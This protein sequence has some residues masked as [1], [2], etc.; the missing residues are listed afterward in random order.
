MID[1]NIESK[2]LEYASYYPV[3]TVTG[4][5][6][7]G[8]TTLCKKVFPDK[9]YISLETIAT[10]DY[11]RE[12][13]HGFLEEYRQG[14]I[15]DE[16]Q[17][18][19]QL[20]SYLQT[21]VDENPV[22]GR[23]ILTGSQHF[24][25]SAS[26]AQSMAGRTGILHLLPLSFDEI[27]RF[28]SAPDA[29]LEAMWTGGYPRILDQQIPPQIWLE[30]YLTTYVQ[31]DV[32]QLLNVGDLSAFVSFVR[33]CAGRTGQI[34]NLSTLGADCGISHNTARAWLSV[35]ETSFLIWRLPA[36][37]T[38]IRKQIV[39]SPKIHFLDS[40]L[41]CCLLGIQTP[42][43]LRHHPLRG[44]IFESWAVSEVVK[45][46]MQAGMQPRL[47][48][49]RDSRGLEVD[50]VEEDG[51][52]LILTELK[53]GQ[54]ITGQFFAPLEKV[55]SLILPDPRFSRVQ[56]RVIYG[57]EEARASASMAVVPWRDIKYRKE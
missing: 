3:V 48:H 26:I 46:R 56:T 51:D 41:V 36:W 52:Q 32:R 21:D 5:R 14:A 35:L 31:R 15:L 12:D 7:S 53:S 24:A 11:A 33:L 42:E 45:Q 16:I 39:K 43:Q 18:A 57:G 13:P 19:P 25:L 28:P 9:R 38:G 30:D 10:R 29:L 1:R 8:K 34:L 40:G 50:L 54:T 44:A 6:Q 23:F 22:P 27:R 20:L 55:A 2:L 17:Q 47:F 49:F 37:H 4:P